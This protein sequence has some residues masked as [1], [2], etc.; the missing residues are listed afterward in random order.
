MGGRQGGKLKPLKAAKKD[1]AE[2]DEESKAFKAK[3]KADAAALKAAQ[4]KAKQHGPLGGGGIKKSSGK[5]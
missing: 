2:D 3:Q 5:K 1:K 4:D